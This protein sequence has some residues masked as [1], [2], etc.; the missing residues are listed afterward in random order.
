M[1]FQL[2]IAQYLLK[3][4]R[5]IKDSAGVFSRT[6]VLK[7]RHDLIILIPEVYVAYAWAQALG[8]L[9]TPQG[10]T[11]FAET[12]ANQ[13]LWLCRVSLVWLHQQGGLGC[14][15]QFRVV[16]EQFRDKREV[17]DFKENA[18]HRGE[19]LCRTTQWAITFH[20]FMLS[21]F[22]HILPNGVS[23]TSEKFGW[24]FRSLHFSAPSSFLC[25]FQQLS[26]HSIIQGRLVWK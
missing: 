21:W 3:F 2:L 26:L 16:T 5:K 1:L 11:P 13:R 4:R 10:P 12:N 6:S 15:I 20:N 8:T 23:L 14:S 17:R 25:L 9:M 19:G 7:M 22:F 24:G 18:E